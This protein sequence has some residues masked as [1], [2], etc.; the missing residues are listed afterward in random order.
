MCNV[1]QSAKSEPDTLAQLGPA[2]GLRLQGGDAKT[3]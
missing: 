1:P 2:E 3:L